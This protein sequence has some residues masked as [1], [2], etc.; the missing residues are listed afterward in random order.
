MATS[1]ISIFLFPLL[2][3]KLYELSTFLRTRSASASSHPSTVAP[4]ARKLLRPPPRPTFY[5]LL[6]FSNISL[7]LL[8]LTMIF[9]LAQLSAYNAK[10]L[11]SYDPFA[12]LGLTSSATPAEIKRAYRSLSLKWH[13]DKNV[14]NAEE[15]NRQFIAITKAYDSLTSET[16]RENIERY[17]NPDGPQA[18]SVSIGLP[19]FLTKRENEMRVLLIYFLI[20][21][22]LP[23]VGVYAVVD[24][25]RSD[26]Q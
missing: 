15:A 4:A 8:L 17:G 25:A 26:Y 21:M 7:A 9:L 1:V 10:P 11:T 3:Y 2:F 6:T 20:F 14:D 19:S 13:P 23:P 16:A 18:M 5:S 24:K 22:V 12:V